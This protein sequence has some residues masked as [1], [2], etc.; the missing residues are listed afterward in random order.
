MTYLTS[1]THFYHSNI[2]TGLSNW[3]TGGQR[4]FEDQYKMTDELIENINLQAAEDDLIRHGGDWSFGGLAKI[5]KARLRIKC[6]RIILSLGNHDEHILS[7]KPIP[8]NLIDECQKRFGSSC[9]RLQDLFEEVTLKQS[10]K[11]HDTKATL[12]HYAERI[13]DKS[14]QGTIQLHGHSHAGLERMF[15]YFGHTPG[16]KHPVNEFYNKHRTM[17]VGIDN[18][19]RIFGEYRM[20]TADSIYQRLINR[21]ILKLMD[22]HDKKTEN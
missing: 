2:T 9:K 8:T 19:F 18:Y 12:Q 3:S 6:N 21:P 7:N 20:F 5:V 13:W 15:Q 1:D 4:E 16:G 22:H 17:D 11:L 10:F 14:H